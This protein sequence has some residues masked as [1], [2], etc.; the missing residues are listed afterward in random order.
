M[1]AAG[2][3]LALSDARAILGLG[4][5]ATA[6]DLRRAF[7]NAAKRAHPDRPGGDAVRFR[8]VIEA[9]RTLQTE[10][11]A[12]AAPESHRPADLFISPVQALLGGA[13]E[14]TLADGRAIRIKLPAGLRHG[15]RLRAGGVVFIVMI[16]PEGDALVR[17]DDVWVT[18]HIDPQVLAEGGR[19]A[20]ET[21]VGRRI[22]WVTRKAAERGLIRL[23]GQ[24]LPARGSHQ[25]GALFLRLAANAPASESE[26]RVLLRRFAAAWAA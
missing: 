15:E 25:Q 11:A 24:G 5:M 1:S 20:V 7:R 9:Y 16:A 12:L 10:T 18:A 6:N 21:P 23:E 14:V 4:P 8:M 26:A 22:V 13:R 19:V 3:T 2:R 17:G